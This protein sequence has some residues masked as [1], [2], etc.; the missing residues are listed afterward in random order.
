MLARSAPPAAALTVGGVVRVADSI[1]SA[2][3]TDDDSRLSRREIGKKLRALRGQNAAPSEARRILG[4]LDTDKDRRLSREEWRAVLDT[5]LIGASLV[6][7]AAIPALRTSGGRALYVSSYSVRQ[8]LPG[9][10][11]YRVSKVGLDALIEGWR[12][13]HPDVRFTLEQRIEGDNTAT[14]H[15]EIAEGRLRVGTGP[16]RDCTV[17]LTIP[18]PVAEGIRVGVLSAQ[19]AFLDGDLRIGGDVGA[20]LAH[21]SALEA[22]AALLA[23][24]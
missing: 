19:R 6:T 20:L 5:N 14:W 4:E 21:R 24:R 17:W 2:S 7:A 15:V 1:F 13:E 11:L 9:L 22:V 10:A 8:C 3:D 23:A 18:R 16:G 12:M